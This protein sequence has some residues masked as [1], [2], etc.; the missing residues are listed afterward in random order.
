MDL[1]PSSYHD[2]MEELWDEEEEPEEIDNMMKVVPPAYHQYFDVFSKVKCPHDIP[3]MPPSTLLTPPP[4][5]C[6]PCLCSRSTLLTCLQCR[7][8][9]GLIVSNP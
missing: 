4:T 8:H 1:P 9:T 5:H 7:P 3:P 2:S 6:L